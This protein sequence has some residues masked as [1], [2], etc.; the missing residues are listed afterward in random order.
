MLQ[1]ILLPWGI[2]PTVLDDPSRLWNTLN[3]VQPQLLVLDVEMPGAN[4]LELCK[5]LRA[6]E[7]WRH[8]PVLFLTVH[9]DSQT[10][11]Q[12]F[13]VGADDFIRKSA[14][15]V[16][17]PHRILNRLQRSLLSEK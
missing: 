12:A 15:S 4:G 10:Q 9:E 13:N 11:Q 5:V 8:L 6:D 16:E 7:K 1:T 14:M 17:L 2:Q 3:D